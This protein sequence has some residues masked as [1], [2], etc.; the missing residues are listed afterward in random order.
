ML[1]EALSSYNILTE[2]DL[3][4]IDENLSIR[5][6]KKG[7]LF[8]REGQVSKEIAFVQSGILRSYY[9]SSNSEEVTYCITFE[10]NFISAYSSFLTQT[11][12]MENVE[13]IT[14]TEVLI[15]PRRIILELEDS[16]V[17]WLRLSKRI[18]EQAYIKLEKRIFLLQRESAEKRYEDLMRNN[19]EMIK[20]IPLH[21]LSSYLGITPRH[22]SR[23]RKS[24]E[25]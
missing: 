21:Y 13:A 3:N 2:D 23:I 25:N 24:F 12:T 11:Q 22:L 4:K 19:P 16:S 10:Q 5:F 20:K 9:H 15:I 14:D 8:I 7:E 1:R 18:A 6:L 17:N